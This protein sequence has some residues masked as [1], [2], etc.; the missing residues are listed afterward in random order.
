[1]E[2]TQYKIILNAD[3]TNLS[4]IK[5]EKCITF[6]I[7]A[8][9]HYRADK[10]EYKPFGIDF[11]LNGIKFSLSLPGRHNL[12]NALSCIAFLSEIGVP[13]KAIANILPDFQG[14]DRRFDIH[15]NNGKKLIIDDYAH[16]P[17]KISA[18]MQTVNK[19]RKDICYIFQPHG[20]APTKMMKK[21]Y[22]QTFVKNLRDTDHLILLPIYYAGG[23]VNKDI[24][25]HDLADEIK[26][27]GKSV[28][29]L[30]SREDIFKKLDRY[31][32]YI[33]FGARDETLSDF[34]KDIA[35]AFK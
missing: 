17:H 12:Y 8:S 13:F 2:N 31:Q 14:V 1:M 34:A 21:E 27:H 23:S 32:T 33:I 18:L 20:F 26:T 6:S 19:F 5:K 7:S 10:V 15:L 30:E 29:V 3:D 9:S 25:S 22:I 4:R 35:S 28:E 11:S 24:S 16:N